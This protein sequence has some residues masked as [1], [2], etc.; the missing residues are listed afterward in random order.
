V[1]LANEALQLTVDE[2][3]LDAFVVERRAG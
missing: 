2:S 3:R 1:R